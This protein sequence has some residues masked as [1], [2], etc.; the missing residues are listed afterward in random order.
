MNDIAA[1]FQAAVVE[2]L[3]EKTFRAAQKYKAR[4]IIVAGGVSANSGLRKA[5]T[6]QK[7]YNVHIPPLKLCTDNAAM[8]AAAGHFRFI[9]GHMDP[10]D[11]DVIPNWPLT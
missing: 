10:L 4:H 3:V 6:T 1:S 7:Q 9:H 5:L 11:F 2:V 8:I